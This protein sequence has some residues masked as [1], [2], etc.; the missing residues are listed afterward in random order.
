M[1]Q[2]LHVKNIA[3]ID[4]V[5]IDFTKGLNILTGET[6]AG[7]SIIIDSVGFALGGRMPKD[8]V[9]D[10]GE[11][12]LCE[13]TFSVEDEYT[14]GQLELLEVP[15]EDGMLILQRKITG[16]KSICRCNGESVTTARLKDIASLLIDVHGQHEHQSLLHKKN[17]KLILD[18]FCGEEFEKELCQLKD[19]YKEYS[20]ATK[21]LEEA[22][23]ANGTRQKDIDYAR[24]VL[25]EIEGAALKEGEDEA[26]EKEY[27]R[28]NNSM[29]IVKELSAVD[30]ALNDDMDGACSR[31]SSC[32][33]A[34]KQVAALDEEASSL[35][36]QIEQVE[37]IMYEFNRSLYSY[38][39]S[40]DFS[41]EDYNNVG[42][43]LDEINRL[44][45]KYGQTISAICKRADEER[46]KVEMLEDYDSYVKNLSDR[47]DDLHDKL[48]GLCRKVSD[49]RK[50][51]AAKL[52]KD[53]EDALNNLNFL[54][55][56]FNIVI[57]ASED[58]ISDSGY[59]EVEFVISTNPGEELKS[60]TQVASGGELSRIMLALKSVVA[61]R[62]DIGTLIFDEID[63]G[64]SG[65][66]AQR[67]ADRMTEI[68]KKHQVICITH[69]PQIASHATTHFLIEKGLQG[70]HTRTAVERLDYDGSVKELARMLSG[71]TI[72]D[73]VLANAAEMKKESILVVE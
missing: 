10:D 4:E 9:R 24:F 37:D 65:K 18:K 72:T 5:E 68:A 50:Q 53:I 71:E 7:K 6:G 12:A 16:G 15:V 43:R 45:M 14:L 32:V 64:I 47:C 41:E 66:T 21:E 38:K 59:D 33:A 69:L 8:I 30:N 20:L 55:A 22:K 63:T 56:R 27:L 70:N 31:I 67:V 49:I 23:L 42:T 11:S 34:M 25:D 57:E 62:D 39:E 52:E 61:S 54:D 44:K 1:L 2:N 36:E 46:Q 19:V 40:L 3:L 17:H 35:F 29:K 13:L 73:A 28:M 48:L 51:E 26:L 60:L 58:K